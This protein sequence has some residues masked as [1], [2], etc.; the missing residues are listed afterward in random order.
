MDASTRPIWTTTPR[1]ARELE[2]KRSAT[3]TARTCETQIS[4]TTTKTARA[5]FA[6]TTTTTTGSPIRRLS[7]ERKTPAHSFEDG[8][9]F[10]PTSPI[11]L[12]GHHFASIAGLGPQL[13][14]NLV[15]L[16]QSRSGRR[17]SIGHKP[18]VGVDGN[19]SIDLG[20]PVVE[21][22]FV[23]AVLI[24]LAALILLIVLGTLL[25]SF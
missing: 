25:G 24:P 23:L 21:H 6:T 17:F 13:H 12:F 15:N 16:P 14:A 2:R 8:V 10:V 19:P 7:P 5:T 3:T 18:P 20:V 4:P 1:R 11:V 22:F 9:D